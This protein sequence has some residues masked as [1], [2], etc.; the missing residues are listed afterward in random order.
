M[1]VSVIGRNQL[2]KVRY[3]WASTYESVPQILG[4]SVIGRNQLDTVWYMGLHTWI[5][6]TDLGSECYRHCDPQRYSAHNCQCQKLYLI[7]DLKTSSYV[8]VK[9][10]KKTKT[11]YKISSHGLWKDMLQVY[12]LEDEILNGPKTAP[13]L[14]TFSEHDGIWHVKIASTFLNFALVNCLLWSL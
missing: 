7:A 11:F 4:V 13:I 5:S 6:S 8:F 3:I 9:D 14:C 12:H 2:N 1:G 10:G